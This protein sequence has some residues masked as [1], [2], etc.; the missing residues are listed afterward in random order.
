LFTLPDLAAVPTIPK[1][2]WPYSTDFAA[3]LQGIKGEGVAFGCGVSQLGT[4]GMAVQI[5]SGHVVIAN[6]EIAVT[7]ADLTITASHNVYERCDVVVVDD[8]GTPSVLAGNADAASAPVAVP[9]DSVL[10]A[11][12]RIPAQDTVITNSQIMDKRVEVGIPI[13]A[14]GGAPVTIGKTADQT[15]QGS[16]LQDDDELVF[17]AGANQVWSFTGLLMAESESATANMRVH[18]AVPSLAAAQW[19]DLALLMGYP[20]P[21]GSLRL[22]DPAWLLV[23]PIGQVGTV[24]AAVIAGRVV[25][26]ANAGVVHLQWAHNAAVALNLTMLKGSF[27]D[28]RQI[29]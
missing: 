24:V 5:A 16:T 26:G 18:L 27:L 28:V 17:S 4:P 14:G 15:L 1:Q 10:I 2:S 12:V 9:A 13:L 22:E 21:Y 8:A 25:M 19:G 6:V 11:M 20:G 7:A 29:V 23:V 3:I